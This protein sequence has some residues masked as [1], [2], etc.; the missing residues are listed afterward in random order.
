VQ[1]E[2]NRAAFAPQSRQSRPVGGTVESVGRL[3]REAVVEYY[4]GHVASSVATFVVACDL[5]TVDLAALVEETFGA[6]PDVASPPHEVPDPVPAGSARA[7]LVDVPGAVQTQFTLG[8]A[9]TDRRNPEW[10][11]LTVAAYAL[12]GTLTSRLDAWLREEK[13][14]TYGVR[15][16]FDPS[17]RG[18]SF[19]ISGSVHTE[20]TGPALA[21][22]LRLVG[23]LVDGG[24][25]D[26]ERA[27]AVD[28]FTRVAPLAYQTANAVAGR[29]TELVANELPLDYVDRTRD[30]LARVTAASASAA[31]AGQIQPGGL[32]LVALGDAAVVGDPLREAGFAHLEVI[33]S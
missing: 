2:F 25:R 16:G 19:T 10:V 31:F 26:D 32:T 6:W 14:Y 33:E 23:E 30:A 28:Y 8:T 29:A 21:D 7:I 24:L 11:P 5:D 1:V 9:A 13:G 17:R 3:T 27:T 20:V 22:T 15:G 12:G 4:T 18:G